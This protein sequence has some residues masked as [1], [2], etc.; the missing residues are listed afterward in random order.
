MPAVFLSRAPDPRRELSPLTTSTFS[1]FV[2]VRYEEFRT[3]LIEASWIKE[4]DL[5]EVAS[6]V[7]LRS[8]AE[9]GLES[10]VA[11]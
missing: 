1:E 11:C 9:S 4:S 8:R 2:S 6:E 10:E 3:H 7:S 5:T